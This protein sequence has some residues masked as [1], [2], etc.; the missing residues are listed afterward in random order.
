[1]DYY[2]YLIFCH[3][4]FIRRRHRPTHTSCKWSRQGVDKNL[5]IKWQLY[6]NKGQIIQDLGACGTWRKFGGCGCLRWWFC[7]V[8]G[9]S[10]NVDIRK[11]LG[12]TRDV[13]NEVRHRRLSYFGHVVRMLPFRVPNLL[14]YGRMA[15]KRP[16]GRPKKRWL[17]GFREDFKIAGITE[18]EAEYMARDR[19]LWSRTVYRLLERVRVC[20][21]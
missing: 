14:R 9:T 19:R 5:A 12:V 3:L 17:D 18:R 7:A 4:Y 1:M 21:I 11:E 13:V 10:R 20:K 16:R 15:G 6:Q 8:L 2:L